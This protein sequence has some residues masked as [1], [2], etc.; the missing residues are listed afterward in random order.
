MKS[1]IIKKLKKT[2]SKKN[3]SE[4]DVAYI[5]IEIYKFLESSNQVN[6]FETIRFYR[7][8]TAHSF[9]LK[10][11]VK[12][13]EDV[14]FLIKAREYLGDDMKWSDLMTSKIKRAFCPYS[15]KYLE[16]QLI[17]FSVEKLGKNYL[18]WAEFRKQIYQ[19]ITD[20]PLIIKKGNNEI[21]KFECKKLNKPFN[22]D[23]LEIKVFADGS[24]F[25]YSLNDESLCN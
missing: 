22:Y 10:D 19:I 3:Y 13:F 17:K 21:F 6:D 9:L 8:W 2:L 25:S 4:Q 16:K 15:F 24:F 14:Y 1:E 11:S 18:K 12:I 23:N 20:T 7:N 5:L